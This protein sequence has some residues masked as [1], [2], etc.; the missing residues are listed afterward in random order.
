ML[1]LMACG[2]HPYETDGHNQVRMS[3]DDA[4]VN[5]SLPAGELEP[6]D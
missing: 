1:L 3:P 2:S 4:A 6:V 5:D